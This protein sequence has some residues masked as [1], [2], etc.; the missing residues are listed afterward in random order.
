MGDAV[1]PQRTPLPVRRRR[2]PRPSAAVRPPAALA[3][4]RCLRRAAGGAAGRS[5]RPAAV[6]RGREGG[7]GE[8]GKLS[9]KDVPARRC[10]AAAAPGTQC[11]SGRPHA[12][13]FSFAA[14]ARPASA[15]RKR[16]TPLSYFAFPTRRDFGPS[17]ACLCILAVGSILRSVACRPLAR[18]A[19]VKQIKKKTRVYKVACLTPNRA[20]EVEREKTKW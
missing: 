11:L 16:G 12:T 8:R 13:S 7:G 17:A 5:L 6:G 9:C 3:P 4:P 1:A 18:F 19:P 14:V 15:T 2:P 20:R 10:S